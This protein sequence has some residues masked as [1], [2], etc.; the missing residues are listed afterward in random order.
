MLELTCPRCGMVEQVPDEELYNL[1]ERTVMIDEK[2]YILCKSCMQAYR[3]LRNKL[4]AYVNQELRDFL[5]GAKKV[6]TV[7]PVKAKPR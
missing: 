7:F 5:A 1:W 3:E 4:D 6:L 2:D